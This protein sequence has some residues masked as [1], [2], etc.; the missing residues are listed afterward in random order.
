MQSTIGATEVTI[1]GGKYTIRSHFDDSFVQR[2]AALVNEK[3]NAIAQDSGLISSD[4]VAILAC[5]NIAS[6]LLQIREEYQKVSI[7]TKRKLE[8]ILSVIDGNLQTSGSRQDNLK[9]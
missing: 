5:M 9:E 3:M 4:K 7:S 8:K 1:L 2:T 6:E